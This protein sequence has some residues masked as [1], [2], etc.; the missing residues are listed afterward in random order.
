MDG[1]LVFTQHV[2]GTFGVHELA[3]EVVRTLGLQRGSDIRI[4]SGDV[5][6]ALKGTVTRQAGGRRL[7]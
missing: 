4:Y 7:G 5:P 1:C 3:S 2:N 6:K